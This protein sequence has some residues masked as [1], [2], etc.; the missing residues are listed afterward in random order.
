M[1]DGITS[2]PFSAE[3]LPPPETDASYTNT[4]EI[5]EASKRKYSRARDGV[6]KEMLVVN[7][8]GVKKQDQQG[9]LFSQL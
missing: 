8:L 1:I 9:S 6:E 2:K 7:L 3:T 4:K 5:I